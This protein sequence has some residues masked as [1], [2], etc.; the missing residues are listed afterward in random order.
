MLTA[1]DPT[2]DRPAY[3]QIAD[4][5]RSA[6]ASG[7]LG[8]GAKVP[9]EAELV[10]TF[11]VAQGTVRNA[12]SQLRTEGLLR[13]E[14][15]KGVF[16]RDRPPMQ[17]K[18]SNRFLRAHR[19]AG[20]AAYTVDAEAQGI[21][22]TVE[23][24][25]VGPGVVPDEIAERLGVPHG[26]TVLVRSRRYLHG[27]TPM[28]I[29][30]SYVPWTIA[31]GTPIA[32]A[33]PGPG[34]IYARIEETGHRLDHFTEDVTAR[35]PVPEEVKALNLTAGTPV[36]RVLRTAYD[37]EGLAVEVCDTVMTADLFVLSYEL[38]AD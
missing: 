1:I 2:S 26:S 6:I 29:A 30:S 11:G 20:K 14:H 4:A 35:M 37:V 33:N 10:R 17:R 28:E 31:E 36:I 12:L 9:S 15:G 38:P 5:I 27:P 25:K 8:P 34:G 18:A 22:H 32:E 21:K 19:D 3:K 24:F 13:A 23:V 16:V 7:E